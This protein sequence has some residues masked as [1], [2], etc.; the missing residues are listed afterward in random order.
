MEK[1]NEILKRDKRYKREAYIF[2]LNAVPFTQKLLHKEKHISGK[3]LLSGIKKLGFRLYGKFAKD[4]FNA[5]GIH[6]TTDFGH[7]VFNLVDVGLLGKQPT[8]SIEDFKDE[9]DFNSGF[10]DYEIKVKE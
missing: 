7:I 2:V 3:E 10:L 1:L 4:V 9:F 5:W 6:S 8:D